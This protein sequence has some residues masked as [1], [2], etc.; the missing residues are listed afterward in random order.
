MVLFSSVPSVIG[1]IFLIPGLCYA[2]LL[3]IHLLRH[4]ETIAGRGREL[5]PLFLCE[6]VIFFLCT[7]GI[8]DF[9]LNTL[10]LRRKRL[11]GDREIPPTLI[12][13]T[14]VPG[15]LIAFR[16]LSGS[17]PVDPAT[18]LLWIAALA[19]GGR[20]GGR[21]VGSLSGPRIRKWSGYALILSLAA[22][23]V[24]MLL[25]GRI[26]TKTGL[27]GIG[28]VP[29]SCIALMIGIVNMLGVP[30]KPFAAA[31]LLLF[32]LSPVS[33]LTL[34]LVLGCV[35]PMSGGYRIIREEAY[36]SGTVFAAMTFGSAGALFGCLFTISLSPMLLN[37]ILILVMLIAIRSSF[38]GD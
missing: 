16:F 21:L 34:T 17:E 37:C 11:C 19:V 10:L 28:L 9:L 5:L 24:R 36:H 4:R 29:L 27:S 22:L 20:I 18:L 14:I 26:G 31:V 8:S 38:S 35:I 13:A 6:F 15:A 1:G 23:I 25:S 2:C 12:A 33:V 7:L 3:A 32:G 30:S